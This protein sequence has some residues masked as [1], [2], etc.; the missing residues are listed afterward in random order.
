MTTDFSN[1]TMNSQPYSGDEQVKIGNGFAMPIQNFG[2]SILPSSS[3][4][5]SFLNLL[6]VPSLVKNLISVRQF[7]SDNSVFLEFHS[8]FFVVNDSNT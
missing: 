5:L 7:C 4:P 6:H 1:L 3:C 2:D 8:D